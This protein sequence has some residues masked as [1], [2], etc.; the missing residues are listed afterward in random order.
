METKFTASIGT[1]VFYLTEGKTSFAE[2]IES[3]LLTSD[4]LVIDACRRHPRVNEVKGAVKAP[5]T[6]KAEVKEPVKDLVEEVAKVET[7][8]T[9]TDLEAMSVSE[10][11]RYATTFKTVNKIK[12]RSLRKKEELKEYINTL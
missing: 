2:F 9:V 11:K 5:E 10:L 12:L 4:S 8:E 1:K 6:P 7:I 3:V